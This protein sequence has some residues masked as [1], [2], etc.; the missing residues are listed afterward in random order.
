MKKIYSLFL[1]IFL[2]SNLFS[3]SGALW[4]EKNLKMISSEWFDIV[5]PESCEESARIL[6]ENADDIYRDIA[7]MY[8]REIPCRLPV[9]ITS[10]V[11]LYNAYYTSG[12]YNHI[13]II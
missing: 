1:F 8:K 4:G 12:F 5:Y 10:S 13:V 3:A 7:K 2:S 6:Y 11:E 9:T